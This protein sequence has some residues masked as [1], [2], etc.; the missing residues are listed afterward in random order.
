MQGSGAHAPVLAR[1][2]VA[3]SPATLLSRVAAGGHPQSCRSEVARI[4][5]TVYYD[6]A[7]ATAQPSVTLLQTKP[8]VSGATY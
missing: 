5:Q 4:Q 8:F 3:P 7:T 6:V 2:G 1:G